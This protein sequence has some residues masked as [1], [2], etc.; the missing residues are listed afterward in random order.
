MEYGCI[1]KKL[2]HSYSADIHG[3]IGGYD[4]ILQEVSE[5]ELDSFMKKRNFKGINVTIPYKK[6]VLPYLDEIDS[7]AKEIGSVN[8]VVN[9]EGKLYGYN[10]DILGMSALLEYAD[11]SVSGRSVLILGT[12]G[13]SVMAQIMC[14]KLGAKDITVVSR[15][16]VG[17]AVS[18]LD[19]MKNHSGSHVIINTTP[20]GMYPDNYA[21]PPIQLSG[22]THL[23]AVVDAIYNPDSTRLV[24]EA[25]KRGIKAVGG[26]YMLVAQAVYAS[27]KFRD[28]KIDRSEILRI[29]NAIR[30]TKLNIALTGM[31]ASGKS[32]IGM[33]VARMLNRRF[34]DTDIEIEKRTGTKISEIFKTGGEER[35]R[36]IETDVIRN[37]SRENGLVISTGGGAILRDEN[38]EA[39]SLNSKVFFLDR[40]LN[41]LK[42]TKDRPTASDFEAMK[43]RYE[44]RYPR[45]VST[46]DEVIRPG[47]SVEDNAKMIAERFLK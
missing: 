2:G 15:R 4:Y 33:A 13:T 45:Y 46:A 20:V 30:R 21:E 8:T 6:D 10:T 7:E 27:E 47:E 22:F 29:Y 11:I 12:G 41:W 5:D 38:V 42:P 19:A 43:K 25:K 26:L 24:I 37:I 17:G 32:T 16:A 31:P 28:T 23:E 18:Y 3:M 14:K 35:F 44:E 39:L 1:A 40:D 9:R 36:D 34:V